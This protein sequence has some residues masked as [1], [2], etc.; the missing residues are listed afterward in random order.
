M[1]EE[2]GEVYNEKETFTNALVRISIALSNSTLEIIKEGH[3]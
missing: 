2:M 1:P 3:N